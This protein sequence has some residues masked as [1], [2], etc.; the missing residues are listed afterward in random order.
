MSEDLKIAHSKEYISSKVAEKDI[1]RWLDFKKV[2]ASKRE[3][4][5]DNI[6]ALVEAIIAGTLIVT[7]KCEL[8]QTLMFPFEGEVVTDKLTYKPRLNVGQVQEK[9]KGVK[10]TDL[11]GFLAA[12]VSALTDQPVGLCKKLDT[13]DNALAENVAIFFL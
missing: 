10:S 6:D 3:K 2:S 11:K 9:L 8:Q 12:Y 13:E 4:L 1:E 5:K 7:E